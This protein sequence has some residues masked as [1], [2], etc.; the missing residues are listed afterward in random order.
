MGPLTCFKEENGTFKFLFKKNH[1]SF[2]VWDRL[3]SFCFFFVGFFFFVGLE[4]EESWRF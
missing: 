4:D 2:Y 1:F 3:G